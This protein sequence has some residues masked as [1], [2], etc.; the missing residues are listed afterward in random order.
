MRR[1]KFQNINYLQDNNNQKCLRPEQKCWKLKSLKTQNRKKKKKRKKRSAIHKRINHQLRHS[2]WKETTELLGKKKTR[3]IS[4]V[5][6]QLISYIKIF[7]N[8]CFNLNSRGAFHFVS[9]TWKTNKIFI[10][11]KKKRACKENIFAVATEIVWIYH[12][13]TSDHKTLLPQH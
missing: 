8:K 10:P 2:H 7:K 13:L 1:N 4:T 5:A 9:G 3:R 11:K 12:C 6:L